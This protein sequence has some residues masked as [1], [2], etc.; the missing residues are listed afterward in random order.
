VSCQS[1]VK[2]KGVFVVVLYWRMFNAVHYR[3]YYCC[4]A[5]AVQ[6]RSTV[7]RMAMSAIRQH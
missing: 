6:T 2:E 4:R 5:S 1:V 3:G 7:V